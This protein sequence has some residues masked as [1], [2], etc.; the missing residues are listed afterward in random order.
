MT[1]FTAGKFEVEVDGPYPM[2]ITIRHGN[3]GSLGSSHERT[4]HSIRHDELID[5]RHVLDRAIA[6]CERKCPG[7]T[8]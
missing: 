1:T 4:L 2:W 6:E 5:L 3:Y 7:E 8:K